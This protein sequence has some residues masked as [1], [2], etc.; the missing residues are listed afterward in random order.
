M[1]KARDFRKQAWN[2]LNGLWG[3]M[4]LVTLVF[5]A[6]MSL[7]GGI[8]FG[9]YIIGGPLTLGAT[10]IYMSIIRKNRKPE[11]GQLFDGFNNFGS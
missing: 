3:T 11:I 6:I 10:Q 9:F 4:A 5:V 2:S 7:S 1:L 8:P